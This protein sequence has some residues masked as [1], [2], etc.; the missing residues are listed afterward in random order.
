[1]LKIISSLIIVRWAYNELHF[2][3]LIPFSHLWLNESFWRTVHRSPNAS[4]HFVCSAASYQRG[5][6]ALSSHVPDACELENGR[7][8]KKD[9]S[10][11][12]FTALFTVW[13]DVCLYRV[14]Q[15][16]PIKLS[17]AWDVVWLWNFTV[18]SYKNTKY[19]GSGNKLE[20]IT[21]KPRM[22]VSI[23]IIIL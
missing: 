7:M 16:F 15:F 11:C 3:R 2:V 22:F 23:D 10:S 20:V 6:E 17:R 19:E 13:V 5:N 14:S 9:V 21:I 1:M 8:K 18:Q 12:T 4:F